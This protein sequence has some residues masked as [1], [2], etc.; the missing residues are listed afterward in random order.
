LAVVGLSGSSVFA[1]PKR[2]KFPFKLQLMIPL[3][4]IRA[5]VN[6]MASGPED[7]GECH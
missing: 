1:Q 5:N 3:A 4:H 6:E 7:F 2:Q